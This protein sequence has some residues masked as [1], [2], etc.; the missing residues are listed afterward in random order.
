MGELFTFDTAKRYVSCTCSLCTRY[1]EQMTTQTLVIGQSEGNEIGK[2]KSSIER[3]IVGGKPAEHCYY[4]SWTVSM[5]T[6]SMTPKLALMNTI[7]SQATRCIRD[8]D[9]PARNSN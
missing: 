6:V 8:A 4:P 3:Q 5:A 2:N 1:N 7:H 9:A